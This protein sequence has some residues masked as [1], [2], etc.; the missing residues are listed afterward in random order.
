MKLATKI[1]GK[2]RRVC[3]SI[4]EAK[5]MSCDSV[6]TWCRLGSCNAPGRAAQVHNFPGTCTSEVDSAWL[7]RLITSVTMR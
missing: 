2:T 4:E 1:T 7:A 5:S 3:K 6:S